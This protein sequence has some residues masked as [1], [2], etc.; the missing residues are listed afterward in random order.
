MES[1]AV[2]V[3]FEFGASDGTELPGCEPMTCIGRVFNAAGEEVFRV[4]QG[5]T[6]AYRDAMLY[7]LDQIT[8]QWTVNRSL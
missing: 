3:T 7:V 8:K 1:L 6:G 5:A 2:S 4:H